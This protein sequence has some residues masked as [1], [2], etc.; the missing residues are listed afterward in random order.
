MYKDYFY[1]LAEEE[2]E[3]QIIEDM[4]LKEAIWPF[5]KAVLP[6]ETRWTKLKNLLRRIAESRAFRVGARVAPA[7]PGL[8][9]LYEIERLKRQTQI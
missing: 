9:A 6:V 8:W 7:V 3:R 4:L 2:L 1:K 5:R